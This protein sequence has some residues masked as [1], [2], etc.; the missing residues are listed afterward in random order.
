MAYS[1][2][3]QWAERSG[4]GLRVVDEN[5]GTGDNSETDFDLDND[6]VVTSSYTLSHAA[7]GS[8]SFTALT[9]T[10]DYTLDQE[11]GRIVLTASGVTA[12]GTDVI[13]ATYTHTP[14]FRPAVVSDLINAADDE[15]D[16]A[17]GRIWDTP[18]SVTEYYDGFRNSEY[19][20]TDRPYQADYDRAQRMVLNNWPVT[21]LDNIYMLN[22]P[23]TASKFFNFDSG[24]S[25]FT[26]KT[27]NAA[28]TTKAPFILFDDNPATGDIVYIGSNNVFLGFQ[29]VLST[30]GVGAST[31]DW[32]Y[33]NGSSWTDL[34][35]TAQ[36]TGA[37][38]FTASGQVTWTYPY[39]WEKT[40]VNSSSQYWIRGTLT[41]NYTTDP[42]LATIILKDSV[43]R[44]IEQNNYVWQSNGSV[45]FV[46]T[47]VINGSQNI[48]FD[49]SY[50][51]TST[52]TYITDL[53]ILYASLRAYINLSGGSYDDATSYTLGSKSVTIGEVYVN[54]R[55][56]IDQ[57][58]KRIEEILSLVG[59]RSDV[60]VI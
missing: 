1:T 15:V 52:P 40:S 57:F 42:Q 34:N 32:E 54:I 36:T 6:N 31:I 55:E 44:V 22:N 8:N 26:D 29:T 7:S 35:E 39:G 45:D 10:T 49:Y 30:L 53:S 13:Y 2:P 11:S 5:V 3:L 24:T 48:R 41:D 38:I 50:G 59:K 37:D 4:I 21:Q 27:T 60:R 23:Q 18:T 28:S 56:V 16:L 51:S 43:S 14:G 25:A 9:E 46:N 20:T 47:S 19:P 33:W 58:K 12:V 17:T